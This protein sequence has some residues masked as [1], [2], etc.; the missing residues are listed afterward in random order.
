MLGRHL[1]TVSQSW[2][3]DEFRMLF[4]KF[5]SPPSRY[6]AKQPCLCQAVGKRCKEQKH[7]VV[8]CCDKSFELVTSPPLAFFTKPPLQNLKN[9]FRSDTGCRGDLVG[10][11]GKAGWEHRGPASP[12]GPDGCPGGGIEESNLAEGRIYKPLKHGHAHCCNYPTPDLSFHIH[13]MG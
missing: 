13:I 2:L 4:P 7:P 11:A 1:A 10:C 12:C 9:Q 6:H 3:S 8:Y 5:S